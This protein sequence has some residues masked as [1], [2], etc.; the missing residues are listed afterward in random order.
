[1]L[2]SCISST[3]SSTLQF[4]NVSSDSIVLLLL[5]R[6]LKLGNICNVHAYKC[7]RSRCCSCSTMAKS[8]VADTLFCVKIKSIKLGNN[9]ITFTKS[10]TFFAFNVCND[11]CDYV[12]YIA[13][14]VINCYNWGSLSRLTAKF[15]SLVSYSTL[16]F[17]N[18]YIVVISRVLLVFY[19]CKCSYLQFTNYAMLSQV[20]F[21]ATNLVSLVR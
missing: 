1:M 11:V 17:V 18:W 13:L 12:I 16:S 15:V 6:A 5:F 7:N 10:F 8:Y 19:K 20:Q 2:R 3:T 4:R 9:L 14:S 21:V